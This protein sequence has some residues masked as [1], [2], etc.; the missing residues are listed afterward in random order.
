MKINLAIKNNKK[1]SKSIVNKNQKLI[2]SIDVFK[3]LSI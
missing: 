2:Y 3:H 1:I